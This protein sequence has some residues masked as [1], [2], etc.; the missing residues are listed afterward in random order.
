MQEFFLQHISEFITGFLAVLVGWIAKTKTAKKVE[1]ADLTKHIQEIYRDMIAD[2]DRRLEQNSIE[3]E[4]LKKKLS[5]QE[6]HY[7]T[8]IAESDRKWQ[9]KYSALQK[10]NTELKKRIIELEKR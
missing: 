5:E 2:T 4:S 9:S 10:Q 8:R 3:I 6:S 7:L 1:E